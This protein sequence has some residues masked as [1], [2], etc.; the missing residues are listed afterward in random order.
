M[1]SSIERAL[2][3]GK[4]NVA[5]IAASLDA[6]SPLKVLSRGYAIAL[7]AEGRAVKDARGVAVGER[8]TVKL[9]SGALGCRVEE[10]YGEQ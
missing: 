8:L 9:N 5:R 1:S 10:S 4:A 3:A 7:D 6:L 2:A